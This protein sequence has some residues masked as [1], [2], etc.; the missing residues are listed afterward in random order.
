MGL[1]QLQVRGRTNHAGVD[2]NE[3]D[4]VL[5]NTIEPQAASL[6]VSQ[7]RSSSIFKLIRD[8][9]EPL[10]LRKYAMLRSAAD[11]LSRYERRQP[12]KRRRID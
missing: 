12:A 4:A 8:M 6:F 2:R 7:L 3:T 10:S 1:G 11:G 5:A 9:S